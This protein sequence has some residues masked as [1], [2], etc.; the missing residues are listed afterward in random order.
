MCAKEKHNRAEPLLC[1]QFPSYPW[2]TV[3]TDLFELHGRCYLLVIGYYS[4]FIELSLL[5]ETTS[6]AVINSLKSIFARHGLPERLISDNGPQYASDAFAKFAKE[7][8]FC[9]LISSPKFPQANVEAERGV[10]TIK[11]MLKRSSDPYLALPAY[12]ST[13]LHNGYSPAELLMSRR[14]RTTVPVIPELLKPKLADMETLKEREQKYKE[15]M[16][17]DF[18]RHHNAKELIPLAIGSQ[19]WVPD[20]QQYGSI[21]ASPNPRS[22]IIQTPS[23]Q[24]RRNRRSLNL[25]PS[26]DTSS[27]AMQPTGQ[28]STQP[29]V[30]P[31][32]YYN[33]YR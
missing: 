11:E 27:E 23:S 7:Y 9:H 31:E 30:D 14:L 1:T 26:T 18:D 6:T 2:Q 16:R 5:T 33:S 4:R 15:K 20:Q 28:V 19:V 22:Y 21:I 24:I 10:E 32:P 25:I 12:R 17:S 29:T 3:A 8:K 13:P